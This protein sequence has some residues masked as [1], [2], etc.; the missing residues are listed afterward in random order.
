MSKPV[1]FTLRYDRL[2]QNQKTRAFS[3][4]PSQP[5]PP[6]SCQRTTKKASQRELRGDA[7]CH[8]LDSILQETRAALEASTAAAAAAATAEQDAAA[9][10]RRESLRRE[11]A[12][13]SAAES[14]ER[15]ES[16]AAEI[17]DLRE[18]AARLGTELEEVC[19]RERVLRG[20]LEA[21]EER[22]VATERQAEAARNEVVGVRSELLGATRRLDEGEAQVRELTGQ[23]GYGR[24]DAHHG[25]LRLSG[26]ASRIGALLESFRT[27]PL[28][29][30]VALTDPS[31]LRHRRP[32]LPLFFGLLCAGL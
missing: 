11:S 9:R 12:E 2:A 4:F 1:T 5:A 6:P 14:D 24:Q 27:L 28:L 17:V 26:G 20:L 25:M 18:E 8:H 10:A 31:C 19:E 15:V 22:R 21:A 3:Q 29:T 16:L 13:N 32:L 23:V 7:E 30:I